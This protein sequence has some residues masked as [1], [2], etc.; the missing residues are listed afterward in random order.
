MNL[1][2]I[3]PESFPITP[4]MNFRIVA[5][6]PTRGFGILASITPGLRSIIFASQ[7]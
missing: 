2:L 7:V 3:H 4:R 6:W 5:N 1:F